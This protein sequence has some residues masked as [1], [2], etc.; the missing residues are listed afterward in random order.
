MR[1]LGPAFIA[2]CTTLVATPAAAHIALTDPAPRTSSQK[3]EPCGDG[4]AK[5]DPVATFIGGETITVTWDE[6]INH[7]SHYR[8]SL[9]LDG[10]DDFADPKTMDDYYTNEAV[11]LDEIAD[12]AGGSYSAE[13]TLPDVSCDT[14]TLQLIQV[15][16]DK[17]PFG[18]GND[19]YHQ[20]AD[21]VI[22]GSGGSTGSTGSTGT[23]GTAGTDGTGGT[24]GPTATTGTETD[25]STGATTEGGSSSGSATGSASDSSGS[26]AGSGDS[27]SSASESG[28]TDEDESGC[29]CTQGST[30]GA[31]W[32][33][34]GL[35]A[36]AIRRRPR[37]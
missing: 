37:C 36:I 26:T 7:P 28:G 24:A 3:T 4:S 16:Y 23:D 13:I 9:D 22:E 19:M 34:F 6:V 2:L 25:G 11:L 33:A 10:E 8:I 30:G 31:P 32:M 12:A 29:G 15:M 14:C 5:G 18:D 35:L 27:S 1:H 20:C 21:I 17:P